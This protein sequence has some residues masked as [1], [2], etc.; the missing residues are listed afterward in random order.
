M[1]SSKQVEKVISTLLVNRGVVTKKQRE[2][3]FNPPHPTKI[4][5]RQVGID[6]KQVARAVARVKKAIDEKE[7]II[8][9]GDYDVDGIC[10]AAIL[11]ETLK[12]LG[13]DVLPYIPS[14]FT[15]GYG[16]NIE[17]IQKLKEEDP[18]IGLIITVDNGIVAH[19][20]IDF[21]KGLGVDVVITDHHQPAETLPSAHAIVHT[22]QVSGSAVA[23][24]FA[25][26]LVA[27]GPVGSSSSARI[28][29]LN[30]AGARRDSS[31]E[32]EPE[33]SSLRVEDLRSRHPLELLADHLGLAALGTVADILP[34]VG[35]NRSLVYHGL[36]ILRKTKRPGVVAICREAGIKQEEIDIFHIG[37]MIAPR[38]NAAGRM[39]H[40]INSLRLLCT[41]QKARAEMLALA[42]GQANRK[43]QESTELAVKHIETNYSSQWTQNGLPK[44]LF[45]YHSS[46]EE[47]VV[48]I[49]A[50]R[51]VEKYYRPAIVV[52][53]GEALSKASARSIAGIDI[54]D[55]IRKAGEGILLGAGGHPMAAGF[56]LESKKISEFAARLDEVMLDVPE[57]VFK[58]EFRVDCDLLFAGISEELYGVIVKFAPFGFGNPQPTFRTSEVFVQDARL[59]GK[60]NEH[61]KL[62]VAQ[63]KEGKGY[64]AIGFRMGELYSRLDSCNPVTIIYSLE[65]DQWNGRKKLQ[66]RLRQV[67]L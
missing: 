48:G 45:A 54:I 37:F 30:A 38:L 26:E 44:V 25:C 50:G 13:A 62:F 20:K 47:G 15:E 17:S 56:S 5:F 27:A 7:K 61:L 36:E 29:S 34:L 51:L 32:S 12:S 4:T 8:V 39:E 53:Y 28:S 16:L 19:E 42:L 10:A 49:V 11:W 14:R 21:A 55:T 35:Y 6:K 24:F 57:G 9:Y 60:Q 2:E 63:E 59:L 40:A 33:G 65:E 67:E 41:T 43:R 46:Y 66:L 3:F 58:R 31:F 52:S 64:E 1:E 18:A 22:T 23:W